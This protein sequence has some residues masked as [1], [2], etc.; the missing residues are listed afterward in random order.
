LHPVDLII[1]FSYLAI[2][3]GIAL[4]AGGRQT[5]AQS[6]FLADRNLPWWMIMFSVVATETS[7]LTFLS[8]PGLAYVT[9]LGFLQLT[10]GYILGR[11]LVAKFLLPQYFEQ[12][13]ESTYEFI[14]GRWGVN[15]QKFT[16]LVF[17][18]TR[19]LADGVRLFMTAIP[20]ALITGWSYPFSI[21]IIGIF[22]LLYT[23]I[24]GIRSVI[25][26][27]S[28]QFA[29]YLFGGV[30]VIFVMGNIVDGGWSTILQT[31]SINGKLKLF[32]FSGGIINQ[33]Y[34]FI[35]ALL[36]GLFLSM[37]SH[38]TDHMMV[39][40]L[41]AV[42]NV[43]GAQKALIGS[44]F[45]VFFQFAIFLILGAGLWVFY[46]N[47][48]QNSNEVFS[49]F[50]ID[51]LPIGLA[52]FIVAGIFSAAM[53]TLSSSINALASSTMTDWIKSSSP[54]KYNLKI[55]RILSVF[56]ALV[57]I[58]GASLFTGTENPL[59]EIGLSI[60]SFTY[61]GLLGFFILGSMKKRFSPESVVSGF[62]ISILVMSFV[63]KFT[64]I[65]WPLYTL[66][67]VTAMLIDSFFVQWVGAVK[68]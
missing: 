8:I 3:T 22:T 6:F 50:I 66:I 20:L 65:A 46:G 14:A 26:A 10:M 35:T 56:W 21:F 53:S 23:L 5:S 43:K 17:L 51:H 24:G 41:L 57:L 28:L 61:G 47:S 42:R 59:V 48:D 29:I 31:A 49:N 37:A 11:I 33:S 63:I 39:Q 52:G 15:V 67:G 16:S 18:V 40:R 12:G 9:D 38:G 25:W 55:S 34:H 1:L 54:E 45:L 62:V 19:I 7:V 58:G 32:H 4:W 13:I 36:G 2:V 27:D 30:A 60:A 44:G 68:K 64:D